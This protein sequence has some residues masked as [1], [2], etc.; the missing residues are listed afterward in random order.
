MKLLDTTKVA[1]HSIWNNKSRS[2]LTT[3]IVAIVSA[4]IMFIVSLGFLFNKYQLLGN[5][6]AFDKEGYY[7]DIRIKNKDSQ[8]MPFLTPEE[9]RSLNEL[10]DKYTHIVDTVSFNGNLNHNTNLVINFGDQVGYID[11]NLYQGLTAIDVNNYTVKSDD[12][13]ING[14]IWNNDDINKKFVWVSSDYIL[15]LLDKKINLTI[16]DDLVI[17]E[18]IYNHNT[19]LLEYKEIASYKITG[20]FDSSK[21]NVDN[22]QKPKFIFDY[23]IISNDLNFN[24]MYVKLNYLPPIGTNYDFNSIYK[25]LKAFNNE[26]KIVFPDYDYNGYQVSRFYNSFINSMEMSIITGYIVIAV[27]IFLGF[28]VLLLSIESVANTIMIS[29]DKNRKF[30]GLLKA[31]GLNQKGVK[32]LIK[33]EAF[34]TILIGLVFGGLI[35]FGTNGI[36][37]L[38][39]Q[40]LIDQIFAY[41]DIDLIVKVTFNPL[42][43]LLTFIIFY[44][45]AILFSKGSL[46]KISSQ[47]VIETI[48]EV[49]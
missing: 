33:V 7:C 39:V 41:Q 47:D 32:S 29:V 48:S 9:L 42:L 37:K 2:I 19:K 38:I 4:L 44:L 14:R 26:L 24:V 45:F 13:I 40:S 11:N 27:A 49:A 5:R 16:G 31:L 10:T 8:S 6:M 21:V 15:S 12:F 36:M 20:I 18:Q 35:S 43:P 17:S 25:D 46:R 3:I 22:Y 23:R 28:V 30:I 34:I 1:C